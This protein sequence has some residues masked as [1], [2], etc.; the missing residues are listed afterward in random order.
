VK[1]KREKER[2][3]FLVRERKRDLHESEEGGKILRIGTEILI[4]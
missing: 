1:Q 4:T 3:R 2:E